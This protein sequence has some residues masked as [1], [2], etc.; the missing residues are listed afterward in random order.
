MVADIYAE[1]DPAMSGPLAAVQK[2]GGPRWDTVQDLL[3]HQQRTEL[4]FLPNTNMMLFLACWS[5]AL[6]ATRAKPVPFG[7]QR[8]RC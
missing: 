7:G 5:V 6:M 1:V 2:K 4:K 8:R 3:T